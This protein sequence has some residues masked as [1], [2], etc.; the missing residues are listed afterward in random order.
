MKEGKLSPDRITRLKALGFAF[1]HSAAQWEAM[2]N[3]LVAYK[4]EHGDSHVPRGFSQ[5]PALASWV[6]SQR[7]QQK[8]GKL[9]PDRITRLESL[10]F[11]F[12]FDPIETRWEAMFQAL[13][14]YKA[15]HGD[16]HVPQSYTNL[17]GWCNNQRQAM[18]KGKLSPDRIARLEAIGFKWSLQ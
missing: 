1:D 12:A 4:A 8:K 9:S 17:G 6:M 3:T 10:G 15:E 16:S 13:V 11:A 14:A 7:A 18:K 2:F 5:N